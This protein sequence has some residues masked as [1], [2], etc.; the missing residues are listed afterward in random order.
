MKH[1]NPSTAKELKTLIKMAYEAGELAQKKNKEL[2]DL[3]ENGTKQCPKRPSF[4]EW[5]DI[6]ILGNGVHVNAKNLDNKGI[7]MLQ[8]MISKAYFIK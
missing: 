4:D 6:A 8:D 7:E 1:D 2:D 3:L 5:F